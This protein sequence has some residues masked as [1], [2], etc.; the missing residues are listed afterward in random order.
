MSLDLSPIRLLRALLAALLLAGATSVATCDTFYRVKTPGAAAEKVTDFS[1]KEVRLLDGPF[2]HA[3]DRDHA[4]LLS[5]E[6]DRLLH[7]FRVNAGFPSSAKPLGGW[8]APDSEVR[9]H[10]VGHYLS[11]CAQMFAS[12]GDD[13]LRKNAAYVIAELAKCQ[14]ALGNG[15][16]SAFPETFID[17]VETLKPVWAPWYTVHKLLA[18][19][20]DN[21]TLCGNTQA[22]DIAEKMARWTK[23]R[24]DKLSDAQMQRMLE[25]EHGGMN[26]GLANLYGL[27]GKKEYLALAERFNH[28]AV[29][30]PLTRREDTLDGLH[31]NT[32]I[33]KVIGAAREYELTGDPKMG[34][35]ASFFWNTVTKDRSYVIG[36]NSDGEH[37]SPKAHLSEY[38]SPTTTETCNTY[39]MLKLTHHLFTWDPRAEYADYYERALFNHILASQNPDTG[40]TCYYVPLHSGSSKGFSTP[41]DSFWCCTGTGVENHAHYGDSIYFHDGAKGLYVNLFI[42]SELDWKARGVTMRQ[43]TRFPEE[44]RTRL[45]FTCVKPAR[46]ALHVRHPYWATSGLRILVNGKEEAVGSV[47]ASYAVL[48]RTWK[49]GDTVEVVAPM[50]LRTEAFKDNPH[51]LAFLYGPIV[52]SADWKSGEQ[53]PTIV[54]DDAQLLHGMT[55]VQDK[56]LTFTGASTLFKTAG[57]AMASPL[58]FQPFYKTYLNSYIVYWDV[59]TPEQWT[60]KQT[61]YADAL[62]RERAIEARSVD[63]I[64]PGEEQNERDHKFAGAQ[65]SNGDFGG[66]KWRDAR[67]GGWFSYLLKALPDAAQELTITYWGSDGGGRDFDILVDG[68]KIAGESL[69]NRHPNRFFDTSY[70][71]PPDLTRGKNQVTVRFQAHSGGM[72]GGVFGCRI[73]KKS[74]V[75]Q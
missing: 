38:L 11:A 27:T 53:I 42:A 47:P 36:G 67:D 16:L 44:G 62:A 26:E 25:N 32:Q 34:V 14:Q 24:M 37:F 35:A 31:A 66:K 46:L 43:E 45:T 5:L 55:P 9:G 22:L 19:M 40:M 57:T 48:S 18:G 3:M 20:I 13:R 51:K 50:Q 6:P 39:N 68:V 28:H 21:Y 2:K 61:E 7:N 65:T 29:L 49:T 60:S 73:M 63:T 10:F 58:S 1:L 54:S 70:E 23:G 41:N 52:L 15:Y 72:A 17:R 59:F 12:T 64:H 8:E 69:A 30:D 4:Y 33:P 74:S 56:P 75:G 71:I